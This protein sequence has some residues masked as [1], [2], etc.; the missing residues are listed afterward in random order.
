ME[1]IQIARKVKHMNKIEKF[2][3]YCTCQQNNQMNETLF[4]LQ[5][6]MFD[7]LYTHHINKV[8]VTPP[9]VITLRTL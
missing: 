3:I 2:N 6:P 8:D 4:D 7:T 9:C 5:N 1:I